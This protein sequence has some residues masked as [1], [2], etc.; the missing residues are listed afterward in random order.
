VVTAQGRRSSTWCQR[1]RWAWGNA[2][3]C[4]R[5]VVVAP[6]TESLRKLGG[7]EI[8]KRVRVR[9][10]CWRRSCTGCWGRMPPVTDNMI[11]GSRAYHVV[12]RGIPESLGMGDGRR[13]GLWCG[14]F[15]IRPAGRVAG[16]FH[17]RSGLLVTY[18]YHSPFFFFSNDTGAQRSDCGKLGLRRRRDVHMASS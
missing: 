9:E 7:G 15:G 2:L 10:P 6:G 13:A 4:G 8:P 17:L 14:F 3:R 1:S 18:K 11:R 16:G 12:K 5:Y